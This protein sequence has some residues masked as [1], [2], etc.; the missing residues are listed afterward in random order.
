GFAD[1]LN[2]GGLPV[3]ATVRADG[4]EFRV[5]VRIDTPKEAD[6]FRHGGILRYVLRQLMASG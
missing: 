5:R 2:A 6:Y 3:H 4:R 1:E